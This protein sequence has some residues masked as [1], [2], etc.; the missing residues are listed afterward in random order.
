MEA[1]SLPP[2]KV[3]NMEFS[4]SLLTK[5]S[6]LISHSYNS[7]LSQLQKVLQDHLWSPHYT[8]LADMRWWH[9]SQH[10]LQARSSLTQQ[11][12]L[13]NQATAPAA[14]CPW[15][16]TLL[17]LAPTLQGHISIHPVNKGSHKPGHSATA[18][19]VST[20]LTV[21]SNTYNLTIQLPLQSAP[22]TSSHSRHV[23]TIN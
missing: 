23:V 5:Q 15:V 2:A 12:F 11:P 10:Q 17:R 20:S 1:A 4:Q 14:P 13:W 8:F 7:S 16:T 3:D 18:I 22:S 19:N 6:L 9:S 21:A